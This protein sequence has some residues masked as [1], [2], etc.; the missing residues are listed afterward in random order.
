MPPDGIIKTRIAF[1]QL[2]G[3]LIGDTV[4]VSLTLP[5]PRKR[6]D[7]AGLSIIDDITLAISK[8]RQ[9]Q[10]KALNI[11][12]CPSCSRVENE[13]SSTWLKVSRK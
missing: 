3:H 8:C 1:E 11:I 4:R 10:R 13:A 9:T 7:E 5:N 12:S 2:I 6:G